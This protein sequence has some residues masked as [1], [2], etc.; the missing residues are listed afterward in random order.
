MQSVTSKVE[1][2]GSNPSGVLPFF[3][4]F[5]IPRE[6]IALP[7]ITLLIYREFEKKISLPQAVRQV[8]PISPS[9]LPQGHTYIVPLD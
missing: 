9:R 2:T 7:E 4:P 6:N 5:A 8:T 3:G 1:V